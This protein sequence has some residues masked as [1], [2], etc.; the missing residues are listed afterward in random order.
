MLFPSFTPNLHQSLGEPKFSRKTKVLGCPK[1]LFGFFCKIV[2]KIRMNFLTNPKDLRCDS[3]NSHEHQFC[4]NLYFS[5]HLFSS[6]G[7]KQNLALLLKHHL[8]NWA[9]FCLPICWTILPPLRRGEMSTVLDFQIGL[10]SLNVKPKVD[11]K[12]TQGSGNSA[13]PTLISPSSQAQRP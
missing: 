12:G 1:S 8:S 11:T 13:P 10:K 9:G 4:L 2:Q 3:R 7:K 6:L 5:A